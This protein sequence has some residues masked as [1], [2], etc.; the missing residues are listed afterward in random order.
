MPRRRFARFRPPAA[1]LRFAARFVVGVGLVAT[2]PAG[3]PPRPRHTTKL[4]VVN[5]DGFSGFFSGTYRTA[6]DLRRQVHRIAD[7]PVGVLE[8]CFSSG[9][10][11][12][13]PARSTELIGADVT[14][15]PR[16]ADKVVAETLRRLADE[17]TDTLAVVAAACRETGLACYASY[18][19]NGDYNATWMGETLPRMFNSRFWWAHPEFRVRGKAGEDRIKLSYAFPE[20]RAFKLALLRE[21]AAR[22]IDGLNLDFLRHPDFFGYEEPLIRAFTAQ[23]GLDPRTL[24]ADDPRWFRLRAE[25]MTGFVRDVR[26]ILGEAGAAKGRRLGLSARLDWKDHKAWGCDLETWLREGLLDYV[27]LAQR[28]LG[29]YAF[30]LAPFVAAARGRGCAVLFGEEAITTGNDLTAQEDKLVA[31]GKMKPPQRG[32][33]SLADYRTRAARWYAAGADG[34]HLFNE[35]RLEVFRELGRVGPA[36]PAP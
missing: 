5:D 29:G 14:E 13:F 10:R 20:V 9:S 17:G 12:N 1:A 30:D 26:K 32:T 35:S 31:E 34:V 11:A 16:R 8:W 28:S 7:T 3:E 23:H 27:V 21:A 33:L 18:R 19:M 36:G 15:F 2:S 24:P 25:I 22:D 4:I 6:D